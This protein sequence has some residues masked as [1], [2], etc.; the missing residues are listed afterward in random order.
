[1]FDLREADPI[2]A[3]GAVVRGMRCGRASFYR[4]VDNCVPASRAQRVVWRGHRW[5]G[6]GLPWQ[7]S[8][9]H[10]GECGRSPRVPL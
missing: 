10:G 1:V 9:A 7:D 4:M 2:G 8:A 6:I 3:R 5:G